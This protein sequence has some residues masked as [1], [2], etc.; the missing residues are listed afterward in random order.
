MSLRSPRPSPASYLQKK[1][2]PALFLGGFQQLRLNQSDH[3][4][5]LKLEMLGTDLFRS[6]TWMVL[7]LPLKIEGRPRVI[8]PRI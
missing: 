7:L 6:A 4:Q 5:P 8:D 3:H 2:V 1:R